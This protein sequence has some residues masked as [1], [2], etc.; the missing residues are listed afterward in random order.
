LYLKEGTVSIGGIYTGATF[1]VGGNALSGASGA[2]I[3]AYSS[4]SNAIFGNTSN[5]GSAGVFGICSG[6]GNFGVFGEASGLASIGVQGN[7]V[8]NDNAAYG[9]AFSSTYSYGAYFIGALGD[10]LLQNG[11]IGGIYNQTIGGT[12]QQVYI[13][14]TG[15]LGLAP[16]ALRFKENIQDIGTV[17]SA[18]YD[19][20]M[21]SFNFK[22][23]KT[24]SLQYGLIA[25]EGEK[26]LPH[27][28]IYKDGEILSWK[29]DQLVPL[30]VNE[31]QRLNNRIKVLEGK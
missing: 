25:E 9:G 24:K 12:N 10:I 4:S 31:V 6:N 7:S 29:Y 17:S 5:S 21:V 30:L 11:K 27:L 18:L 2:A 15:K 23:D 26:V 13:D 16:S 14:N 28:A 20:R 3:F 1:M 19:L 22:N 8:S